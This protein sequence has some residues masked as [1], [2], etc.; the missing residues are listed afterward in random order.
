MGSCF[1]RKELI[2]TVYQEKSIS[3]AAQKLFMSQP[4]LNIMI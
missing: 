2:Y 4:S 1:N 3:K